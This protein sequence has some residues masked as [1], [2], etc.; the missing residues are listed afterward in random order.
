MCTYKKTRTNAIAQRKILKDNIFH[1]NKSSLYMNISVTLNTFKNF[2]RLSLPQ[3]NAK[4][5]QVHERN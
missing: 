5:R 1:N 3:G 2:P 4:S